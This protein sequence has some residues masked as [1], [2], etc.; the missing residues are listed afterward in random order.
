MIIVSCYYNIPSKQ[1]KEFYYN[2]ISRFFKKITWQTIVFF[3]D[4]E[5]YPLLSRLAGSNVKFIIQPFEDSKIFDVFS[6]EF[7]K[8]QIKYVP[9]KYHTWQLGALWASKIHFVKQAS[10]L[11]S[12][13]N[14][15]IWVDAGSVRSESWN[16]T[17]NDNNTVWHFLV[18]SPKSNVFWKYIFN[19]NLYN[20]WDTQNNNDYTT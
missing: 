16:L 14:W 15:F 13:E 20:T 8:E 7:W 4:S 17:N 18:Q 9:E 6:Q 3:T 5:N 19:N 1:P 12:S 11:Y 2:H 10:E